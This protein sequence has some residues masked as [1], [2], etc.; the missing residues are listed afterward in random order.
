MKA[1][2]GWAKAGADKLKQKLGAGEPLGNATQ[3]KGFDFTDEDDMDMGG[4][5]EALGSEEA[6]LS[7][8]LDAVAESSTNTVARFDAVAVFRKSGQSV[9]IQVLTHARL[10]HH[11]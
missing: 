7:G 6:T 1:M 3:A 9:P 2:K 10:Y 5:M 4:Y 11:D 8:H